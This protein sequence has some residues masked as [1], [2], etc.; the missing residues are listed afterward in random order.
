MTLQKASDLQQQ[1]NA[2]EKEQDKKNID[3]I[4]HINQPDHPNT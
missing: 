1:Q 3:F 4:K 2:K